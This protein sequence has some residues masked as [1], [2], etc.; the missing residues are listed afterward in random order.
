MEGHPLLAGAAQGGEPVAD[1][2]EAGLEAPAEQLDVVAGRPH[3]PQERAIGHEH[4][5]GE[6]VGQG[7]PGHGP[8]GF[9]GEQGIP[10][11]LVQDVAQ[12]QERP[13][14]RQLEGP[15]AQR[16]HFGKAQHPGLGIVA[17]E[18][19]RSLA[20]LVHPHL[21]PVAPE[22]LHEPG[23][24]LVQVQPGLD[25]ERFR[26]LLQG[27]EVVHGALDEVAR[28]LGGEHRR[29]RRV[30][31]AVAQLV[32]KDLGLPA[33]F[34]VGLV[35]QEHGPGQGRA[36]LGQIP[37]L[38]GRQVQGLEQGI[39]EGLHEVLRHPVVL[40]GGEALQVHFETVGE[41]D[42]QVGGEGPLVGLDQVEIAGTYR[43]PFGHLH[44]AQPLLAPQ[45][46]DLGP[47]L[48]RAAFGGRVGHRALL[49]KFYK[50]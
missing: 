3:R 19:P 7:H 27:R 9:V 11:Q 5:P 40:L 33:P 31:L 39:A 22:H 24:E 28:R 16:Q 35:E 2:L 48:G 44:L 49:D 15:A 42:Q 45:G 25:P 20:D 6:V 18:D 30:A 23:V 8:R 13:L 14:V 34:P 12:G 36:A 21:H 46:P 41:A 38:R 29:G 50:C 32:G 4:G 37:H 47:E 26:G 43:Q 10:G 1:L 17:A